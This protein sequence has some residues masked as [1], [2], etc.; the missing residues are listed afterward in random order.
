VLQQVAGESGPE[1]LIG[2]GYMGNTGQYR[3]GVPV[4]GTAV[5]IKADITA[6]MGRFVQAAAGSGN[7]PGATGH[8][9]GLA[10]LEGTGGGGLILT[11]FGPGFYYPDRQ[12]PATYPDGHG[13]DYEPDI[14][15][16]NLYYNPKKLNS[17][18]SP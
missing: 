7:P 9:Q 5:Y 6:T 13:Q 16:N 8:Q 1:A 14:F 18:V 3:P 11:V 2:K 10:F 17:E 4:K 15:H 12:L